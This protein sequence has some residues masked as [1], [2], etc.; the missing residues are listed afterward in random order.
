M[1]AYVYML[2]CA[3][4]S[5]YIARR[6]T[7]WISGSAEHQAGAFDVY[8]SRH[9]PVPLVFDQYFDCIEDAVSAERQVKGWGREKKE[10]LIRGDYAALPGLTRRAASAVRGIRSMNDA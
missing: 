8:T 1:G 7:A 2:R 10:T 4:G 6:G 5:C 9:R 3:D